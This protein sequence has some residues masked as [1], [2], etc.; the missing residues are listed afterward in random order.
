MKWSKVYILFD[1]FTGGG[2]GQ[3]E[4]ASAVGGDAA[5]GGGVQAPATAEGGGGG[6]VQKEAWRE[7]HHHRGDVGVGG[8][9]RLG[10]RDL[11]GRHWLLCFVCVYV[12]PLLTCKKTLVWIKHEGE[13]DKVR[14][15]KKLSAV[16]Y[17]D[18]ELQHIYSLIKKWP[19]VNNVVRVLESLCEQWV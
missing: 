18:F 9:G 15:E 5:T 2:P 8:Q 16:M 10:G 4:S 3:G 14:R 13:L 7:H 17:F 19:N 12:K 6:R 11:A 1:L